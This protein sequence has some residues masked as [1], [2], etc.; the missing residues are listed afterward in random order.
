MFVSF[1][2]QSAA[3]LFNFGHHHALDVGR[4]VIGIARRYRVRKAAPWT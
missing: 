3:Q 2:I 4:Y 1:V